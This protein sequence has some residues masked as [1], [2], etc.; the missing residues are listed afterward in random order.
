M[1]A[2]K[3]VAGHIYFDLVFISTDLYVKLDNNR[4][5]TFSNTGSEPQK[6]V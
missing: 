4:L 5:V 6:S 3:H 2:Q 1:H